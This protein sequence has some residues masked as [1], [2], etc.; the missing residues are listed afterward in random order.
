[1]NLTTF[2]SLQFLNLSW[3]LSSV[4]FVRLLKF[5]YSLNM[6]L[7]SECAS[8]TTVI[9]HI[10]ASTENVSL[11]SFYN[12]KYVRV[13]EWEQPHL[14]D[15]INALPQESPELKKKKTNCARVP[16]P[17]TFMHRKINSFQTNWMADCKQKIPSMKYY[18]GKG[19]H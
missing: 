1:M 7:L 10:L 16:S 11:N 13:H 6:G 3:K 14:H 18:R 4:S 8:Y 12:F 9:M 17:W 15:L 2:Y 19:V 5:L